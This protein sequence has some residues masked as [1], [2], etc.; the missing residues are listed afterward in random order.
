[1]SYPNRDIFLTQTEQDR[2]RK[3]FDEKKVKPITDFLSKAVEQVKDG[4]GWAESFLAAA[5]W[6]ADIAEAVGTALPIIGAAVKLIEKWLEPELWEL[7]AIACTLAYQSAVRDALEAEKSSSVDQYRAGKK[8]DAKIVRQIRDASPAEQADLSTFSFEDAANHVFVRRADR[9][10][11]IALD[12]AGFDAKQQAGI[13]NRVHDGFVEKLKLLLSDRRTAEKFEPFHKAI[14]E[15][16][17]EEK[18]AHIALATHA[19]YQ[20]EQYEAAPVF[21]FEPFALKDVYVETECGVLEWREIKKH[22]DKRQAHDG[23]PAERDFSP[24]SPKHGGRHNLINTVMGFIRD[25]DFKEAIVLQGETGA[26]KSSFTIRLSTELLNAGFCPIRVRLKKLRLGEPLI[27]S[28]PDA[29]EL[30]D[31]DRLA[32]NPL[33]KP[34]DM[35]LGGRIFNERYGTTNLCRY[36]LILDGWDELSLADNKSF[37]DNVQEMLRQVRDEFWGGKYSTL[38]RVLVTGRPSNE[39]GED[40]YFLR[41]ET[42]IL[43]MRR[44]KSA[45]LSQLVGAMKTALETQPVYTENEATWQI[46]DLTKFEPVFNDN[47]KFLDEEEALRLEVLGSPLLAYLAIRVMA[48]TEGDLTELINQPTRL[49]RELTDLTCGGA[50]KYIAD[51]RDKPGERDVWWRT[52]QPKLRRLL[53]RTAAAMTI[54]GKEYISKEQLLRRVFDDGENDEADDIIAQAERESSLSR[55][56]VSFFFKGGHPEMGC[57]FS[58]KSFREYLTAECIV[59]VLKDFGHRSDGFDFRRRP[60]PERDFLSNGDD[61]RHEFSRRLSELLAPQWLKWEVIG[62]LGELLRWEIQRSRNGTESVSDPDLTRVA[63]APRTASPSANTFRQ[64]EQ[65]RDGLA[66]LWEWWVDGAH[67]RPQWEGKGK[68]RYIVPAYVHD[69]I[70]WSAPLDEQETYDQSI[71][72]ETATAMDAHMG[73]GLFR[74]CAW[75]HFFIAEADGWLEEQEEEKQI[76]PSI[77]SGKTIAPS[78]RYYQSLTIREKREWRVFAPSGIRWESFDHIIARINSDSSRPGWLFPSNSN[79]SGIDFSNTRLA[80]TLLDDSILKW[81]NLSNTTLRRAAL[82]SVNFEGAFLDWASLEH[83]R[84]DGAILDRARLSGARLSG[85]SLD[86]ASLDGASL[87]G[88]DLSD[89]RNLT[90]EQI[91]SAHIDEH[92]QLPKEFEQLKQEMLARQRHAESESEELEIEEESDELDDDG[93]S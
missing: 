89:A 18:R 71:G 39:V 27:E 65:I 69:L 46:T 75:V 62:Y 80:G 33:T 31:E 79:L 6:M 16:G 60:K 2:L 57:E 49:Y 90:R 10:L 45:Q 25:P 8:I 66:D 35:L 70:K 78:Q 64:W 92:T 42:K 73:D 1:M 68:K 53:Q 51:K 14:N 61:P 36:V 63:H 72:F 3:L 59:E 43:T 56:M 50:G 91:E 82:Y 34:R 11:E 30:G 48:E 13:F 38:V 52:E 87:D 54:N 74:L 37:R 44:M 5:P 4:K 67:L 93:E 17:N 77:L 47:I 76:T 86:G 19:E 83:A 28:L 58:H 15:L 24:F 41:S 85:A 29:I 26:G 9:A 22:M 81:A 32:K 12:A 7:G 20:R 40:K 88:A 55:L 23:E 84:L 21:R